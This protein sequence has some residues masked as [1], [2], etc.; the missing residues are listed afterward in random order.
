ML[1][2]D[3][4][5]QYFQFQV[6][7]DASVHFLNWRQSPSPSTSRS[8]HRTG[9]GTVRPLLVLHSSTTNLSNQEPLT[10]LILL[11]YQERNREALTL[12]NADW[13]V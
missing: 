9:P 1:C 3:K 7:A 6:S 13:F 4:C 5:D 12:L 10:I 11:A 8:N 2:Y